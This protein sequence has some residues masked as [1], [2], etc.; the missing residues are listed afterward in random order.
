ML[1]LLYNRIQAK[2]EEV[3]TVKPELSSREW[4]ESNLWIKT[5]DRKIV[6]LRL[7]GIQLAYAEKKTNRDL[8]LK[9]RQGGISTYILAEFFEDAA[10][11]ENT[12]CIIVAHDADST[13]K[14]FRIVLLYYD[15]LPEI[16][17]ARLCKNPDKPQYK[18]RRELY[19]DRI[20]SRIEVGTAGNTNFGRGQTINNLHCSE[21]AFWPRPEE[22][23]PGLLQAVPEDGKVRFESTPKGFNELYIMYQDCKNDESPN[24]AHFFPWW[25][26]GEYQS[27][28][29]P[30]EQMELT[31]EERKLQT[32]VQD[33]G[34]PA[35]TMEQIKWRRAKKKELKRDFI[36]EYPEDDVSCFLGSGN[37]VFEIELLQTYLAGCKP[38]L[39]EE[40]NGRLKVWKG[41]ARNR[42]YVIGADV[43][44][45]GSDGDFS[46]AYVTDKATGEDVAQ[47]KGHWPPDVFAKKLAD[48]GIHYSRYY[49]THELP[50]LLGVERN[51]HG[52]SV[53]NTLINVVKY[54]NVYR[55]EHYDPKTRTKSKKPGWPTDAVTKPIM[56]DDLDELL[57]AGIPINSND[58]IGEALTFVRKKDGS[59]GADDG[60]HD[61][62]VIAKAIAMQMRKLTPRRSRALGRKPAG[63]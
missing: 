19:F 42:E 30:G 14:L 27:P 61:D 37:C 9:Y 11:H 25:V 43:A 55:H 53:L 12:N 15:R 40:E 4:I 46:T 36:Q 33:A 7:N 56:I 41:P 8:I 58:F 26:H 51:N 28:L 6:P 35:L 24:I 10:R 22:I 16:E 29:D 2:A 44:E 60:C 13:E 57:R 17:K 63:L 62:L 45:G 20:N 32:K 31:E 23:L 21:V 47:L 52:H 1:D 38:P 34:Y 48:L 39:R 59:M 18:N 54:P 3:S 50:P 49:A 5:K